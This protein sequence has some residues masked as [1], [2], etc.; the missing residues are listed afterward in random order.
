[1]SNEEI[2]HKKEKRVAISVVIILLLTEFIIQHSIYQATYN[3][4][5]I[6]S[7]VDGIGLA[8]TLISIV[9]GIVA[10]VYAFMQGE[11]QNRTNQQLSI[12]LGRMDRTHNDLESTSA[13]LRSNLELTQSIVKAL[14]ELKSDMLAV[15]TDLRTYAT[16]KEAA[17]APTGNRGGTISATVGVG[18]AV[19]IF[20]LLAE[21]AS[22]DLVAINYFLTR[23][24]NSPFRETREHI[25]HV[26]FAAEDREM[27]K[28]DTFVVGMTWS[29]F[30]TAK[31][32]LDAWNIVSS[33]R[34]NNF[35]GPVDKRPVR[36]F[37]PENKLK[38]ATLISDSIG[39]MSA[40][41][42]KALEY[43]KGIG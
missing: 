12:Q 14:P 33:E 17:A 8:G 29:S 27:P 9:L 34:D 13:G 18:K 40:E 5:N 3:W 10:I 22:D 19:T 23:K 2:F 7:A 32:I 43:L 24:P 36:Y 16:A 4:A 31:N 39:Q 26:F 25:G 30:Y 6:R 15:R 21:Q 20:D 35:E 37:V 42:L 28:D 41:Q 11:S 1:M 38:E